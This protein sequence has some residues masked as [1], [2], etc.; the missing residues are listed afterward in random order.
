MKESL[1][2]TIE[3]DVDELMD[4]DEYQWDWWKSYQ[5][6]YTAEHRLLAPEM[7]LWRRSCSSAIFRNF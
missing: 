3:L 2:E 5:N 6:S 7:T 1:D 4:E